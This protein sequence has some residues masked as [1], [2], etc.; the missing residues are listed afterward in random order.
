MAEEA[1]KEAVDTVKILHE[2]NNYSHD[3]LADVLKMA[4]YDLDNAVRVMKEAGMETSKIYSAIK[5][6]SDNPTK[7]I[8]AIL[9]HF[10]KKE[11]L[12]GAKNIYPL[13]EIA[14]ALQE[15]KLL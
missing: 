4:G 5:R 6:M 12:W 14:K 13:E 15:L 8:S 9:N 11:A 1:G 7:A 10:E 3:D 2:I